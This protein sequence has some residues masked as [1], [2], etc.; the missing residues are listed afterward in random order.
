MPIRIYRRKGSPYYQLDVT[1]GGQRIRRSAQTTDRRLA[2]EAAATLEAEL[3]RAR[4]HGERRGARSFAQAVLSYLQAAP[5]SANQQASIDRLLLAMGDLPLSKIDQQ[6]A[7]ELKGKILRP[8]AAPGTYTRAIVMPLRAILHHAHRLGWCDPPHIVAPRE[9]PG[10]TLYLLPDEVDRLVEAAAPHLQPLIIFLAGA[11]ARMSEAME[12]DWRDVDLAGGRAIFWRTKGGK[13]RI[14]ELSPRVVAALANLDHRSGPVFLGPGG[15]PYVDRERRY[16][17]QVK[18]AWTTA[19]KRVGLTPEFTPH[20]LRHSW[21]SWEYAQHKDL[22]KLKQ[23][24]GWSS[25][26]LVERYAH[27]L[28]SGNEDAVRAWHRFG[29][30]DTAASGA[31]D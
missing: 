23:A 16:G 3:F 1:V 18:T 4:W 9:N 21:A 5:R 12:L 24:G 11:G 8:E 30:M 22:I 14:A 17:G 31:S 29:T 2:R 19:R 27:L 13:R 20:V 10:R 25:V 28:P 6:L 7:I 26:M 15:H